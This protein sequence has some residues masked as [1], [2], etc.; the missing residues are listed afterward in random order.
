MFADMYYQSPEI[1]GLIHN[2]CAVSHESFL[3]LLMDRSSEWRLVHVCMH[4][5]FD[6]VTSSQFL[7]IAN[8]YTAFQQMD[9]KRTAQDVKTGSFPNPRLFFRML[10]YRPY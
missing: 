2:F 10:Y 1:S 9:S 8:V 6:T 7:D 5:H 4:S 3:P